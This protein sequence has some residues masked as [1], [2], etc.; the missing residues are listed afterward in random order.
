MKKS[1]SKLNEL[2]LEFMYNLLYCPPLFFFTAHILIGRN[3]LVHEVVNE[4]D[5][6]I[7]YLLQAYVNAAFVLMSKHVLKLESFHLHPSP[8]P[9]VAQ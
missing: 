6:S 4:K 5:V 8:L 2:I 7:N 1:T 3:H 9:F